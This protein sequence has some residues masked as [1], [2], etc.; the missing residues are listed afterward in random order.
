M[1][2]QERD[3][4]GRRVRQAVLAS[5]SHAAVSTLAF[6]S[7]PAGEKGNA[8]ERFSPVSSPGA[9]YPPSRSSPATAPASSRESEEDE[10]KTEESSVA[11]RHEGTNFLFPFFFFLMCAHTHTCSLIH[12]N[13]LFCKTDFE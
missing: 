4:R 8:R 3:G 7:F 9:G 10:G 12:I 5:L 2:R 11:A 6:L 13:A 1:E